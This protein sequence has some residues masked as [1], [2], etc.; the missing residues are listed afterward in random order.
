MLLYR[1]T[2]M[3]MLA[4]TN[5]HHRSWSDWDELVRQ[6]GPRFKIETKRILEGSDSGLIVL[7]WE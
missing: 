7:A 2:D 3:L 5:S 4:T 1:S 6:A